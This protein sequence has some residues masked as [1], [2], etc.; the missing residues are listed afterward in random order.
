MGSIKQVNKKNGI[1]IPQDYMNN[2]TNN[3]CWSC[4]LVIYCSAQ[5][6]ASLT[7]VWLAGKTSFLQ[8]WVCGF[9][10]ALLI[11][12]CIV[13]SIWTQW[14]SRVLTS[15]KDQQS[16]YETTHKYELPKNDRLYQK[17]MKMLEKLILHPSAKSNSFCVILLTNKQT[18]RQ[19]WKRYLLDYSHIQS[20]LDLDITGL[21]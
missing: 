9:K 7:E 10:P 8:I 12:T 21:F 17:S 19:E 18:N 2:D 14:L 16:P 4:L 20:R 3:F 6:M 15:T 1:N 5:L 13:N 11:Y